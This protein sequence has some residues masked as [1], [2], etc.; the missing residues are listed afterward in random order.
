MTFQIP[1]PTDPDH[2]SNPPGGAFKWFPI[3][4]LGPRQRPRILVH[5]QAL[6]AQDRYLRFGYAASDAHIAR[7]VDQLDFDRDEVFGVFNRRLELVAMA[8]LAYLGHDNEPPTSAEFGVSVLPRGRGRGIGARLFERACLHARNRGI[9]NLIVHALSENV[10]MLKIARSAGA[11]LEREGP[12]STARLKLPRDD[13]GSQL[14]QLVG[15][16][17]AEWDYG[18]KL[19]A[20]RFDRLL[21]SMR[22]FI[23]GGP[24]A[25]D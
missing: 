13:L 1:T 11:V 20:V 14:S 10:A 8:H 12:D 7:Y 18:L 23:P 5:L 16:H 4:S 25:R 24:A 2:K 3:R 6:E 17:A 22:S 21:Q 19:Q 15:M 9:D